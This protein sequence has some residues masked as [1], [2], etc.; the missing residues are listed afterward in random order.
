MFKTPKVKG[1]QKLFK[2]WVITVFISKKQSQNNICSYEHVRKKD[3][4][5]EIWMKKRLY[6]K[7]FKQ[8]VMA[9]RQKDIMN[10]KGFALL[11]T[12][13]VYI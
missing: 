1:F 8:S 10:Y 12:H 7:V 5:I 4:T 13:A 3:K 9:S 2:S 6:S 11:D